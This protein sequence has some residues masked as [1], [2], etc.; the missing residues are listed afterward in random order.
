MIKN[1][2][3]LVDEIID[4]TEDS[5]QNK[6]KLL[7]TMQ[8]CFSVGNALMLSGE[9]LKN[10]N[11]SKINPVVLFMIAKDL[12]LDVNK[13]FGNEILN[14]GELLDRII[15]LENRVDRLEK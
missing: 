15:T 10:K 14:Y 2:D 13:Y 3:A 12:G 9:M 8:K 7:S 5:V 4:A 1:I 6:S 11:V